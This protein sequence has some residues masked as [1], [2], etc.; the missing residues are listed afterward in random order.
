MLIHSNG[1]TTITGASGTYTLDDG[2]TPAADW[3]TN[4]SSNGD[5]VGELTT[6]TLA[7]RRD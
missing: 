1:N 5:S 4:F 3:T 2:V 6:L 7:V